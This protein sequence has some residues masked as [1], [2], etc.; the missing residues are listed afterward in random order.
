[1][2]ILIELFVYALGAGALTLLGLAT[3]YSG[4]QQLTGGDPVLGL[5]FTGFGVVLL[6]AGVYLLGY[7]Q[8]VRRAIDA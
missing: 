7:E 4:L 6:Y 5:W 2:Q 8:V 3:E 1:M